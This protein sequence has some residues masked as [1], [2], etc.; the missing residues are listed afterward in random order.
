MDKAMEMKSAPVLRDSPVPS[1]VG[2]FSVEPSFSVRNALV[3]QNK[4]HRNQKMEVERA[5]IPDLIKVLQLS[6]YGVDK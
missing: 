3:I 5:D 1:K 2:V 6:Y 4:L